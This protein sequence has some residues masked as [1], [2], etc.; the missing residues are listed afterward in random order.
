MDLGLINIECVVLLNQMPS[1]Q[2]KHTKAK[3][4]EYGFHKVSLTH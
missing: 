2:I 1:E 3:E 4:R